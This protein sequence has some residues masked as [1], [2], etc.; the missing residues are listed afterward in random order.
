MMRALKTLLIFIFTICSFIAYSQSCPNYHID[1][2]RWAGDSF[3][4]SRQSRSALYTAGMTSE[5]VI[6]VYG[7]E[8]YYVSVVG[9]KK[10]GN[11][12]IKVM[13]DNKEKT[14]LYDNSRYKYEGYFYFKNETSRNL[15]L[16]VTTEGK[17]KFSQSLERFC[18]GVLIQFRND[19]DQKTSTGFEE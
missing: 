3:L 13:E 7:G 9:D 18:L 12:R 6:T 17:K 15:I 8:E 14:A 11:I 1:E 16:E 4:Y 2:C 10:L 19:I 5:F